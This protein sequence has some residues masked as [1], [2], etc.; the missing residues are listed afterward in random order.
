M[1]DQ[2]RSY[3]PNFIIQSAEE[4]L[5]SGDVS[6]GQMLFQ[7]ALLDWADD[8]RENA[9]NLDQDQV[10]EAMATLWIAYASYNR[11]AKQFK[12]ATEAYEQAVMDDT[13]RNIGRIWLEYARFLEER[14]KLRSSQQVFLRA[15]VLDDG[16][17]VQDE[18]DRA[19]LWNEFLEM[20]KQTTPE[21][22]MKDLQSA[23]EQEHSVTLIENR[24]EVPDAP[25]SSM[26]EDNMD[27]Y[28]DTEQPEVLAS[29]K[30]PLNSNYAE[31]EEPSRTHVVTPA[32][33][34]D[35]KTNL[36]DL[37][38]GAQQDPSF[39]ASWMVRDGTG[40]PQ[41]PS[42]PLFLAA[43][44][45]LADPTGKSLL[46]EEMA[47]ILIHRLLE[48]TGPVL[49]EVCRACWTMSAL[50][51]EQ[52][53]NA[54]ARL[55][56][57]VKDE[58]AKLNGRLE[59]RLSVSGAAE[60][61]VRHMND[62]ERQAFETSCNQ[63]RN[64]LLH[65][66]AW[67]FRQLLW[68]QQQLLSKLNVPGFEMGATVDETSLKYQANICSYLHSAFY[69]RK[70]IGAHAH[71]KML[72]TH[73]DRLKAQLGGAPQAKKKSRFSPPLAHPQQ[74]PQ[75]NHGMTLPPPPPPQQSFMM[76]YPPQPGYGYAPPP[77]PPPPPPGQP[78]Y[79]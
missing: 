8:F 59:E 9:S 6:G 55:D 26:A 69:L 25:P 12:S 27:L 20:M 32:D 79:Y 61:A 67:N 62:T 15:L 24:G 52:S 29:K 60:A 38:K 22:T 49:L 72:K 7:S 39:L 13:V 42:P 23:I 66:Q 41:P 78:G 28:G 57:S 16:G 53:S 34:E 46:G 54:L 71:Q 31:E 11:N 76:Q 35:Y 77:P 65:N 68:I 3:D 17:A 40:P 18:Q 63:Q 56:E 74:Q 4:K 64:T 75:Y 51:E 37:L 14:Q 45:Q 43:P 19:L 48:P 58:L 36:Q 2:Q 1:A 10:R 21:L 50:T 70:R 30:R 33:I 47:Q 73:A 44:P 5:K